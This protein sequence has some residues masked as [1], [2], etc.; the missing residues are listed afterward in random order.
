MDSVGGS[1]FVENHT[2]AVTAA[3]IVSIPDLGCAAAL[4]AGIFSH[5]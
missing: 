5:R 4:G 3:E 2:I 1:L